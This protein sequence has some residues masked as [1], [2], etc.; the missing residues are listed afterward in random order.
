MLITETWTTAQTVN[1]VCPQGV[2]SVVVELWG[3]GGGAGGNVVVFGSAPG[4]GGGA[5]SKKT[6]SVSYGNTYQIII[7]SGGAGAPNSSFPTAGQSGQ[8]S[9]FG[10]SLVVAVGGSGGAYLSN[11]GIGGQSSLCVGDIT[12]SG[13][14]G[15]DR[16][17]EYYGGGGGGSAGTGSNGNNASGYIGATAVIGGGSGGNAGVG[18]PLYILP[19]VAGSPGGGGGGAGATSLGPGGGSGADGKAVLTYS[20]RTLKVFFKLV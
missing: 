6:V 7:G 5:Y 17:N 9:V 2:T 13:G 19:G 20:K 16:P 4:G 10:S 15:S 18:D 8:N 12:Y 11:Y 1:W 14:N 3:G